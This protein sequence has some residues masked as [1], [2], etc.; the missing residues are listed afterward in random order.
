MNYLDKIIAHKREE[1]AQ[2][3]KKM[4]LKDLEESLYFK[5]STR[6]LQASILSKDFGVIAEIKRKSPSKGVI[7]GNLNIVE[8][9]ILYEKYGA[10]GISVLTDKH[11]FGGSNEDLIF[12]RDSVQLP[13]L[14]KDFIIDEYQVFEA[15][16]IGAD[17]ILL[18]AEV[19]DKVHLHE[20]AL[21]ARSLG[22]EV[23]LEI[24]SANELS[25]FNDEISLLG[26]NNRNL[27]NQDVNL[28]NSRTVF[29]YLPKNLPLI[30]ESGIQT[31]EDLQEMYEFGFNGALI[32]TSIVQHKNPGE[33]LKQLQQFK[34]VSL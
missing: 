29:P 18:I 8:T 13:V 14:R 32:G 20:L 11:F 9:A 4:K 10:A 19:L 3:K 7:N 5:R 12:V 25:K 21:I 22:M 2:K 24:H 1:V 33:F 28:T 23:L 16:S 26:V 6:S 31:P 17:C 15:K 27:E 34:K 30:S